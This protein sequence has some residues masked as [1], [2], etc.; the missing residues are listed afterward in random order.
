MCKLRVQDVL[1]KCLY[2]CSLHHRNLIVLFKPSLFLAIIKNK[3]DLNK[4]PVPFQD[5]KY[6]EKLSFYSDPSPSIIWCFNL[7]RLL[8]YSKFTVDNL[9]KPFHDVIIN[10]FISNFL[11]PWKVGQERGKFHKCEYLDNERSIS[12]ETKNIL[13]NFPRASFSWNIKNIRCQLKILF[14]DMN[15]LW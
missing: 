10:Y 1:W 2:C 13:H 3:R 12:G 8:S 4:L 6:V 14:L 15:I 9:F 7:N 5:P 11:K